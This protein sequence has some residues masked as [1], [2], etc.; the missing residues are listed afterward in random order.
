MTVVVLV[1]ATVAVVP[2][3]GQAKLRNCGFHFYTQVYAS[4]TTRCR[5]AIDIIVYAIIAAGS[6]MTLVTATPTPQRARAAD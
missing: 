5:T 2:A 3:F 6:A 4:R 1:L